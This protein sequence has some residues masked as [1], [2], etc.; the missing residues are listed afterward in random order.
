MG[1]PFYEGDIWTAMC[2]AEEWWEMLDGQYDYVALYHVNDYFVENYA[3]LF[4]DPDEITDNRLF[5]VNRSAK[6]LEVVKR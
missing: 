4:R 6:C 5:R 3:E 2:S 1:T